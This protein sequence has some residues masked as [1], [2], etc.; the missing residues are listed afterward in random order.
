MSSHSRSSVTLFSLLGALLG[1]QLPPAQA[2][3]QPADPLAPATPAAEAP[4]DPIS[5]P[6]TPPPP[7]TAADTS[8]PAPAD[9]PTDAPTDEAG[10]THSRRPDGSVD[11]A[12]VTQSGLLSDEQVLTEEAYGV[13]TVRRGTDPYED[14]NKRYFFLGGFY[15][16]HFIP[17][18]MVEIFVQESPSISNPQAGLELTIRRD[19]FEI[20]A[21]AWYAD[22]TTEGPFL[23]NG[24]P[25]DDVEII[26]SN[27]RTVMVGATFLWSTMFNDY[28]GL[29]YGL[30]LG[31]GY[32]FGDLVRTEAYPSNNGGF[33]ACTTPPAG[34]TAG[35]A[36]PGDSIDVSRSNG[37]GIA[38]YCQPAIGTP[39]PISNEDGERGAHYG[40][41]ARKWFDGGSVPNL[42]FRLAPQISLRIKPIHQLVIRA[43]V[44]FDIFSGIYVGAGLGIGLN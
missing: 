3:A 17:S 42:W 22:F 24:D 31:V 8:D 10:P 38:D 4:A 29:E 44:G 34:G 37:L 20:I 5:D 18:G 2:A 28:I 6:A 12:D 35:D 25:P 15:R 9:S 43:D 32:V 7:P 23:A 1:A 21:S 14:P 36:Q 19:S 27:L 16:H 39:P 40:V 30:G 26:D 13:E 33:A 41:V 11:T